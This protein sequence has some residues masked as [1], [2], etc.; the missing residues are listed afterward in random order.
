MKTGAKY[1]FYPDKEQELLIAK[2]SGCTRFVWNHI[3]AFR[4]EQY[5]QGVRLNSKAISKALTA[6]KREPENTFL[7]EVSMVPLQQ[8][9]INQSKAF[10]RFFKK[11]ASFPNFKKN[12]IVRV[13]L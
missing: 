5:Q 3:L 12:I 9:L 7:K 6:L 13:L 4:N 1:R 10:E 8:V 11:K 2:T